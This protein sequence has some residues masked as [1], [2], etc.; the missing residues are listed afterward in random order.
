[1]EVD[2]PALPA[3]RRRY[4]LPPAHAEALTD[5]E[6]LSYLAPFMRLM[7]AAGVQL[8]ALLDAYR[9][10]TGVRWAACGPDMRS[11]QADMNRPWFLQALAASGSPP[12]PTSTR[13]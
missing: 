12:C 9:S 2:D 8:P 6:S 7:T 11:G 3:D 10:G 5:R 13:A 4:H 1:M